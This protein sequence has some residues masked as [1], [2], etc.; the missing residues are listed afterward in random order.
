MSKS[1]IMLVCAAGMSTSM[2]VTKM[3]NA[4]KEK[5][6]DAE[7]FAVAASEADKKL[8]SQTIDVVLLGPQVR[9]MAKQFQKKLEPLKIPVEVINMADYGMMNGGKVLEQAVQM[10]EAKVG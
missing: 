9:F 2:L 7:I 1:I 6:L 3:Q 4:A 8:A 10:M 5:G